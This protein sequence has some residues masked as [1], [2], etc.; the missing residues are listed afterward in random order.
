[1][2]TVQSPKLHW[3][4]SVH[5]FTR[6]HTLRHNYMS[7]CVSWPVF[8]SSLNVTSLSLDQSFHVTHTKTP[9]RLWFYWRQLNMMF[10]LMVR[11]HWVGRGE[12][13]YRLMKANSLWEGRV[14]NA[15]DNTHTLWLV[16]SIVKLNRWDQT[17]KMSLP[18][19]VLCL[20]LT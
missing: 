13:S 14:G 19:S 18:L 7:V 10:V 17:C 8:N 20:L 12:S 5:L 11:A 15:V 1:M 3:P 9:M 2:L 6:K 4:Q 16:V